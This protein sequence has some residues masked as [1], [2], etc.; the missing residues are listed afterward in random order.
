MP[1]RK[2]PLP[3]PGDRFNRL[4]VVSTEPYRPA[5]GHLQYRCVCRCDCGARVVADARRLRSG[6]TKSCGCHRK[7]QFAQAAR[8]SI[9]TA[10]SRNTSGYKGV[11]YRKDKHRWRMCL[12]FR[13]KLYSSIHDTPEEAAQ[14]YD[15]LAIELRGPDTC[16][17]FPEDYPEHRNRRPARRIP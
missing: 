16:I 1:T 15:K 3:K 17:N 4:T 12:V 9:Y 5:D 10:I 11:D 2:I 8:D 14:A 13:G 7:E 6:H